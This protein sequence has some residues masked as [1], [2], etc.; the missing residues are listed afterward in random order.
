LRRG[1]EPAGAGF[2]PFERVAALQGEYEEHGL[3]ALISKFRDELVLASCDRAQTRQ[4]C[5]ELLAV[6]FERH[7]RRVEAGANIDFPDLL[8]GSVVVGREGAVGEAGED[9]AAA[10]V[11]SVP[12]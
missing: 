12:L 7:R 6:D 2:P 1:R 3:V 10:A 11:E 9:E 4:D 5:D 8:H